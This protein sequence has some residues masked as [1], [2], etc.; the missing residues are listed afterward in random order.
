MIPGMLREAV[1]GLNTRRSS[2]GGLLSQ[3]Q[4]F[5]NNGF[6]RSICALVNQKKLLILTPDSSGAYLMQAGWLQAD[7]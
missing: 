6:S 3:A 7:Q 4:P 1:L 5:G 2:T